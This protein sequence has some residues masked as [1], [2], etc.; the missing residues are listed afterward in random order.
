[1]IHALNYTDYVYRPRRP[2]ELD[3]ARGGGV[4]FSQA[5]HQIDIVRLLGG[6]RVKTVRA[7]TGAWDATRPS[8]GAYSAFLTFD[9]GAFATVTYNGYAHFDSDEFSGWIG[10]MGMPKDRNRYGAARKALQGA[11]NADEESAL[12]AARNY[13]GSDYAAAPIAQDRTHQHFGLILVSCERADLRPLP[14]GVAIYEDFSSRLEPVPVPEIPRAEV[15]DEF[16]GAV[17]HGVPP[18]H[19][20]AWS[21]ATMEVCL[22]MLQSARTGK[23]IKLKHQVDVRAGIKQDAA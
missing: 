21:L 22:A 14:T 23:E 12:K 10:E 17:I 18:L 2:E 1:M 13:G 5:A 4:M 8:E 16:Y 9:N 19:G 15:I 11:A 7:A 3:T 20:G 6:G